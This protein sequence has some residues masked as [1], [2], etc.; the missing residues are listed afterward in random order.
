[1][2]L[3]SVAVALLLFALAGGSPVRAQATGAAEADRVA[4]ARE[5]LAVVGAAKQFD[6]F[7][8]LM[9]ANMTNA[10]VGLAPHAE[11]EIKEVMGEMLKRFSQ[12]KDELIQEVARLYAE[13]LSVEE[14]AEL[15]RFY[16]SG[17][18]AKFI[19]LQPELIQRSMLF[20]QRWGER[21]GREVEAEARRELKKRGVDI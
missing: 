4:A 16:S 11:K 19:A 1:V 3:R 9:T 18:G 13:K 2:T 8:P 5:L 7:M 17:V 10:F 20:G 12:R 14:I 21:I 15:T 6:Q